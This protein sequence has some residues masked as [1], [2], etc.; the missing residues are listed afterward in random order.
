[1]LRLHCIAQELYLHLIIAF[2]EKESEKNI[3]QSILLYTWKLH[4]IVNQL[5]LKII[6]LSRHWQQSIQASVQP[7]WAQG[8]HKCRAFCKY[9]KL[10]HVALPVMFFFEQLLVLCADYS[11]YDLWPVC[12][13][14]LSLWLDPLIVSFRVFIIIT[15]ISEVQIIMALF[16]LIRVYPHFLL[17]CEIRRTQSHISS[18]KAS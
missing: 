7:F 13:W 5:K 17:I 6:Q 16:W 3:V 18:K 15:S 9:M 14:S 1:M 11:F 8:H 12:L 2:I 4:N 10:C